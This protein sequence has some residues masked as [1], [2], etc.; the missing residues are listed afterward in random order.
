MRSDAEI[1]KSRAL[2]ELDRIQRDH[3]ALSQQLVE[4]KDG[5]E[6]RLKTRNEVDNQIQARQRELDELNA[7]LSKTQA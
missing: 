6:Q 2:D 3:T 7:D 4:L 1:N 5:I